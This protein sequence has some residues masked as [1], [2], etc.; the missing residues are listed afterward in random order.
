MQWFNEPESWNINNGT[1]TMDVTP[2]S[3]YWR[4]SPYDTM[5]DDA[6]FLYTTRGGEFEVK[7]RISGKYKTNSDQAGLMLKISRGNYIKTGVEFVDGKYKI[8]TVESHEASKWNVL[9]VAFE[10][11]KPTEYIWFKAIKRLDTVDILYSFDD[12]KYTLITNCYLRD[13]A[14]IMVG[15]IAASPE[16]EGFKLSFDNFKIKHLPD[17]RRM[18]WLEKN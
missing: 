9:E 6:P 8:I 15:V 17:Q 13:N 3:D 11:D 16:G 1:I 12:K 14:P 4:V 7:V 18:E 2:Y 5:I 10:L